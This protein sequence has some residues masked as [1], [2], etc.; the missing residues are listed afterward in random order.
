MF[1]VERRKAILDLLD[2]HSSVS[3]EE[4]SK[5]LYTGEATIRRD[6]DKMARE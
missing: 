5:T 3:V 2:K 4:L 6:L 1:P